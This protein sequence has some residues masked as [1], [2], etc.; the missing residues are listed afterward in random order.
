MREDLEKTLDKLR[1]PLMKTGLNVLHSLL[2]S[3]DGPKVKPAEV[4]A[5][6]SKSVT[7]VSKQSITNAARRLEEAHAINR[8]EGHYK[9]KYGYL[10]SVLLH[11]VI[12]L[13]K[14]ILDMEEE[15]LSLKETSEP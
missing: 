3:L 15:I 1:N 2:E 13:N 8:D 4:R 11:E 6:V 7:G 14:K 5:E 12:E 10:I 9:V